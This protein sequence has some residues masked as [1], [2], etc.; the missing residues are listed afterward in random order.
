MGDPAGKTTSVSGRVALTIR[1]KRLEMDFAV[2]E[3]PVEI[4]DMLPAFRSVAGKF[5]DL[6][7]AEEARVGRNVSCQKGCG[8]C[9]RQLVPI[10]MTEAR[11]LARLVDEMPE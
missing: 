10:S 11:D 6:S 8:A 9:C 5:V 1:G 2:P 7:I 4:T 3:G